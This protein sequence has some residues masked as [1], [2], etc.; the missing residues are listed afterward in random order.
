[1]YLLPAPAESGK[2]LY[3]PRPSDKV[4]S[5]V[6]SVPGV[7]PVPCSLAYLLR[8]HF[9]LSLMPCSELMPYLP[10]MPYLSLMSHLRPIPYP[11]QLPPKYRF[12]QT[13][14]RSPMLSDR[15]SLQFPYIKSVIILSEAFSFALTPVFPAFRLKIWQNPC[16]TSGQGRCI[17]IFRKHRNAAFL[18]YTMNL[19]PPD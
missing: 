2:H 3:C 11:A 7:F 4:F 13:H 17:C 19:L 6:H 12:P 18:H 10:L 14:P 8:H 16:D 15:C 5:E 1:M 9:L